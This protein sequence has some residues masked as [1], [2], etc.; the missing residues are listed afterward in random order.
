MIMS[1]SVLPMFSSK[2]FIFVVCIEERCD[3]RVLVQTSPSSHTVDI[4]ETVAEQ[5]T[6]F[7]KNYY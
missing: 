6:C 4:K 1:E 3:V 7:L 5:N 2:S